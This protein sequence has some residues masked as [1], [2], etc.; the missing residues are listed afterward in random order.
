MGYTA[1]IT[2]ESADKRTIALVEV[3]NIANLDR[4]EA[5]AIRRNLIDYFALPEDPYLLIVSQEHGYL[6]EP[7]EA[8]R[9]SSEPA[10]EFTMKPV[11]TKFASDHPAG[12]RMQAGIFDYVAVQ[13]LSHLAWSMRSNGVLKNEDLPL[14]G[15]AFANA[16]SN[17]SILME[18][19]V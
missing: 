18:A 16:I 10:Q 13:W 4:A 9:A 19:A 5:I 12:V 14:A 8:K 1:D 7:A 6:W 2:I 11:M 3:F 15:S 17:A